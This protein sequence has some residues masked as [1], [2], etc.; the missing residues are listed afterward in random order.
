MLVGTIGFVSTGGLIIDTQGAAFTLIASGGANNGGAISVNAPSISLNNGA[1]IVRNSATAAS[2]SVTL[3]TESLGSSGLNT[4]S[5]SANTLVI[6]TSSNAAPVTIATQVNNLQI[7]GGDFNISN[8]GSVSLIGSAFLLGNL[9]LTTAAAGQSSGNIF[10]NTDV[11]SNSISL[12]AGGAG[13]GIYQNAPFA[14]LIAV[15]SVTLSGQSSIIASVGSPNLSL[16]TPDNALISL[17]NQNNQIN[18]NNQTNLVSASANSLLLTSA[19]ANGS[20]DTLTLSGNVATVGTLYALVANV[21][22]NSGVSIGGAVVGVRALNGASGSSGANDLTIQNN[23]GSSITGNVVLLT[24]AAG[25]NVSLT[26]SGSINGAAGNV[27]VVSAASSA[28]TGGNLTISG[29]GAINTAASTNG[30]IN[31]VVLNA[32]DGKS[33]NQIHFTGGKLLTVQLISMPA[34]TIS[35]YWLIL[36]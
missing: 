31:L 34:A 9:V 27:F 16:S 10:I 14:N 2:G 6:D 35:H 15:N 23:S 21:V 29:N 22:V 36:A 5:L 13:A 19:A 17:V 12:T 26:N 4:L 24:G 18:N 11:V 33:A 8:S 25:S 30:A 7:S 32:A 3:N 20:T 28:D 1:L